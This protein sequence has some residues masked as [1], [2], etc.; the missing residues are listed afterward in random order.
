MILKSFLPK[1]KIL[2]LRDALNSLEFFWIL[3]NDDPD[4]EFCVF[5]L[6]FLTPSLL[7]TAKL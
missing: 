2:K 5:K 1:F 4:H 7:L 6:K 3:D